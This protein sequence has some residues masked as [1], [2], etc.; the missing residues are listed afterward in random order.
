MTAEWVR[1][2]FCA[3]FILLGMFVEF[4]ALLG[5]FRFKFA[6]NRM[7]S[8]SMG[9]TLGLMFILIGLIIAYGLDFASLKLAVLIIFMWIASP[10][11]SHLVAELEM[12]TDSELKQHMAIESM[13]EGDNGIWK[14]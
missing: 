8:A 12:L 7:H 4:T 14:F 11:A 3:L 10:V 5:V 9:D 1:F 2:G 6:L 13:K